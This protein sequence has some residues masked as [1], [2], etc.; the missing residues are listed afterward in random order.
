MPHNPL[1]PIATAATG[2]LCVA[3]PNVA[4]MEIRLSPAED[5]GFYDRTMFPA[6]HVIDGPRLMVSDAPGL[7]IEVDEER[8]AAADRRPWDPPALRRRDGSVQNW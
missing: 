2:H 7:G 6:Q 5:P 4:W 3:I 8:V 1:G